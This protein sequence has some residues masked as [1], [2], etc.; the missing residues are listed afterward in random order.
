MVEILFLNLHYWWL[1]T[2][3]YKLLL[4]V[5]FKLCT[6][7]LFIIVHCSNY[8]LRVG[9][10]YWL[11]ILYLFILTYRYW[12][13]C[14]LTCGSVTFSGWGLSVDVVDIDAYLHLADEDHHYL[15]SI[16]QD[17]HPMRRPCPNHQIVIVSKFSYMWLSYYFMLT[18]KIYPLSR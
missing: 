7:Y 3:K 10:I 4:Y 13:I 8:R 18:Y 9:L 14:H 6:T 5:H 12:L 16:E 1:I 2:T 11:S 17:S 15:C